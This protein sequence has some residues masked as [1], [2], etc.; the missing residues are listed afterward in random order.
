M[1]VMFAM[2]EESIA[3][4]QR[5]VLEEWSTCGDEMGREQERWNRKY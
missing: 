1:T 3:P 5:V 4:R 2:E